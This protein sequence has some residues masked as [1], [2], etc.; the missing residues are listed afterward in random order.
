[1][2]KL[3]KSRY[4]VLMGLLLLAFWVH[5][6]AVSLHPDVVEKLRA[7]GK[8]ENVTHQLEDARAR[9]VNA[10]SQMPLLKSISLGSGQDTI[11][12]VVLL[13]E[14]TDNLAD[15]GLVDFADSTYF[16]MIL[17]SEGIMEHGSM[18]EYYLE[19]SYGQFVFIADVFGWFMMPETYEYYVAG[20]MGMGWN[21]PRNSQGLVEDALLV[22]DP[23]ID[24]SV[25]DNFPDYLNMVEALIVVHAGPGHEIT[26]DP[27][28]IHSHKWWLDP[29]EVDYF[30]GVHFWE[31]NM[32]PEENSITEP[33]PIGIGVFCHEFGHTLGLP[34]LYDI[35]YSSEGIGYWS[36]MAA[37]SYNGDSKSPAHLDAWCKKQLGWLDMENIEENV[38][39]HEFPQVETSGYAA[40]LWKNGDMGAEY[41][42]IENRQKTGFD[43]YLPDEGLVIWHINESIPNN[44]IEYSYKVALEQADGLF[45]L[46]ENINRGDGGDPYPGTSDNREFSEMT[47]PSSY[48]RVGIPSETAV[49]NISDCDD[50]M[51]ANLDINYTRPRFELFGCLPAEVSG[52]GDFMA[53]GG[54]TWGLYLR[55]KN[56]RAATDSAM[57]YVDS[58]NPSITI[59]QH[60]FYLGP[61]DPNQ[62]LLNDTLPV[63]FTLDEDIDTGAVV[64]NLKFIDNAETD[65]L[66]INYDFYTGMPKVLLVDHDRDDSL[67]AECYYSSTFDALDAAYWRY[68]RDS[69][70]T[71]GSEYLDFPVIVWFNNWGTLSSGDIAFLENYLDGG[72]K[73]FLC[74]QHIAEEL[75]HQSD[76]LFLNNYLKCD[77][78]ITGAYEN[79]RASGANGSQIG[80][81]NLML[82]LDS[83][84]DDSIYVNHLTD[85][86]PNATPCLEYNNGYENIG[87]AGVE[88]SGLDYSMVFWGFGFD[89]IDDPSTEMYESRSDV[90]RKVLTFLGQIITDAEDDFHA[91]GTLPTDFEL[92]Q[93]YPNPFN[94][95]TVIIYSLNRA[96]EGDVRLRI[97]NILGQEI[98]ILVNTPQEAGTYQV[99]WDGTDKDGQRVGSGIYFY[100]LQSGDR[101][102]ARKMILL[103]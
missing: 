88:Y 42:L 58:E 27:N 81:D 50:T 39:G 11:R 67:F 100:R 10:P 24:Y 9:G 16:D 71:P 82:I 15:S 77:Y 14:F 70:G 68:A 80:S 97:Y 65:S 86:D 1:M 12:A 76:T 44:N 13:V 38:I 84:N 72:G 19:N 74:G 59:D 22:A 41:F 87:V 47:V 20:Q 55:L 48:M 62:V 73:L 66:E 45:E 90:M 29:T 37:G 33:D 69:L 3:I 5:A 21:Y 4:F 23:Y 57:L 93:N 40:R 102:I 51:Y 75:A 92:N 99:E 60:E 53:E 79:L 25:Y 6:S 8:L 85:I 49:W 2:R 36:L 54:E 64:I 103:K 43:S 46:E 30:D 98:K 95:K 61:L 26:G 32:D 18:R 91:E 94:P 101:S 78:E 28:T 96:S 17:N 52:D 83:R 56:I 7:E 31:Y 63:T 89:M 34:D 35:D